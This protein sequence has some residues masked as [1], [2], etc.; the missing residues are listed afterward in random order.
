MAK[1]GTKSI[2]FWYF[3]ARVLKKLLSY[4]KSAPSNLSNCKILRKKMPK[5]GAKNALPGYFWARI[6]ENYCHI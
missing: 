1:F 4:L 2:L 5:F 6:L 3:W